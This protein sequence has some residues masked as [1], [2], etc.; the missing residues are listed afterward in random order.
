LRHA[1]AQNQK[2]SK[3]PGAA[4]VSSM[5]LI[6][7]NAGTPFAAHNIYY[8]REDNTPVYIEDLYFRS[9]SEAQAVVDFLECHTDT[10]K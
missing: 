7:S 8:G 3:S 4:G 2:V 6:P 10:R 5:V 1:G 9:D